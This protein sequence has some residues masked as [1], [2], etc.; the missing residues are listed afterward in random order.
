MT[1]P[2]HDA[3][4]G[5][6]AGA[7][8]TERPAAIAAVVGALVVPDAM[9]LLLPAFVGALGNVRALDEASIGLLASAD[10]AG[11]AVS[12]ATG[13]WWVRRLAWRR[14]I[15]ISLGVFLLANALCIGTEG[16]WPLLTLRFLAGLS[17]GAAYATALAAIS[18][19]KNP[20]RNAALMVCTQ[21]VFGAVGIYA[22]PYFRASWQ[23]NALY[24]YILAWLL[25]LMVLCWKW[26]PD[27]SGVR[28]IAVG[29]E[30]GFSALKGA[31]VVV[32]T[33]GFALTVGAVW[34]YLERV[35]VNAG[36]EGR[37]AST[38]VSVGFL[39]SLIGSALAA[40]QGIRLGR[41]VPLLISGACQCAA[42]VAIARLSASS[43]P[44]TVFFIAGAVFQIAWCYVISYQII[45]F[46]DV[47][48][49]GRFLPFYGTTYHGAMA[50]GPYL[51]ALAVIGGRYAPLLEYG[52]FALAVSY[53][54]FLSSVLLNRRA[55]RRAALTVPT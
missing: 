14:V 35:A 23:L 6:A 47:D 51:G 8:R 50:A 36:L 24:G 7:S 34:G 10:L 19:T 17:G 3:A 54:L 32:A 53:A 41:I 33:A 31:V 4:P 11:I 45:V 28:R 30:K 39:L 2:T 18:D 46:N 37:Q 29:G 20:S 9:Y 12:T 21:I 13:M 38:A 48:P 49:T 55:E 40:W 1:I 42:L 16:F 27:D 43:D 22:M 5:I 52:S 26:F 15:R 44:V 25:P